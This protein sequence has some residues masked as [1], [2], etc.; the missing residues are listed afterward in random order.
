[1]N[2]VQ[3][4]LSFEIDDLSKRGS[5]RPIDPTYF[6]IQSD[7]AGSA[8]IPKE[9]DKSKETEEKCARLSLRWPC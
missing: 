4:A 3:L 1:M 2:L 6:D 7:M 9:G 5:T 8:Q